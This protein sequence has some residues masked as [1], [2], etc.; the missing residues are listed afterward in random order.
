MAVRLKIRLRPEYT[1]NMR[2]GR[3]RCSQNLRSP[4]FRPIRVPLVGVC[5]LIMA[6]QYVCTTLL[7]KNAT[8]QGCARVQKNT[9]NW[10]ALVAM[11]WLMILESTFLDTR[12][13][14]GPLG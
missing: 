2:Q 8:Y 12:L 3:A 7:I 6:R 5:T 4:V 9:Q 10:N 11:I 1:G 14:V 13:A